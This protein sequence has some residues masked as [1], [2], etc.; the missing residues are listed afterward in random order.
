MEV[1][2]SNLSLQRELSSRRMNGDQLTKEIESK[3]QALDSLQ[4]NISRK[5]DIIDTLNGDITAIKDQSQQI[6]EKYG[7]SLDVQDPLLQSILHKLNGTDLQTT[8]LHDVSTVQRQTAELTRRRLEIQRRIEELT[9]AKQS[10]LNEIKASQIQN[11]QLKATNEL[12]NEEI[13]EI[14][15]SNDN[16]ENLKEKESYE[17]NNENLK[18][19]KGSLD[20]LLSIDNWQV[21][22]AGSQIVFSYKSHPDVKLVIT[23]DQII[24]SNNTKINSIHCDAINE[25][26]LRSIVHSANETS[27]DERVNKCMQLLYIALIGLK[28]K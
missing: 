15:K 25:D 23:L 17:R 7:D 1:K 16:T 9:R 5:I 24:S 6:I 21:I 11:V 12:M 28:K 2:E 18:I 19:I 14:R 22:N 4:Q 3:A 27:A 10:K 8:N 13:E 20:P 26:T